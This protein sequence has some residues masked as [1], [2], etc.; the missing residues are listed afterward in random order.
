MTA[1]RVPSGTD[2]TDPTDLAA[3]VARREPGRPLE[4]AFYVSVPWSGGV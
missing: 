1:T 4:G 2:L 3:L